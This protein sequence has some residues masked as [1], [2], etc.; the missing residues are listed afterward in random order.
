MER[1]SYFEGKWGK[2]LANG[3][4]LEALH[5]VHEME[6]SAFSDLIMF[7]DLDAAGRLVEQNLYHE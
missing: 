7:A 1:T 6:F 2:L 3:K 5:R 4:K